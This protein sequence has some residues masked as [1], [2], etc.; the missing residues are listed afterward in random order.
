MATGRST[1]ENAF[2]LTRTT[3][4]YRVFAEGGGYP[5]LDY[6]ESCNLVQQSVN[7]SDP[8]TFRLYRYNKRT[9]RLE[10]TE[11]KTDR[12]LVLGYDMSIGLPPL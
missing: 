8:I 10:P 1:I 9:R 6:L 11:V 5:Q 12:K 4:G 7:E 2:G 3:T